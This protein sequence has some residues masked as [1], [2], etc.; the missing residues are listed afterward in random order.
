MGRTF[1]GTTLPNNAGTCLMCFLEI[2]NGSSVVELTLI[3]SF[4]FI[5]WKMSV[6]FLALPVLRSCLD[7]DL[8]S[9]NEN[10]FATACQLN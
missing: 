7:F 10:F 8:I 6:S 9:L 2:L 3:T 1:K 5:K 4:L